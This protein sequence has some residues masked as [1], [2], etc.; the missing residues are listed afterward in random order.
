MQVAL[1]ELWRAW[2][3]D[4]DAVIGHS[5]GEVAAAHVAGALGLDDAVRVIGRRSRL[6]RQLSG[7]GA[8][9]AVDLSWREAQAVIVGYEDRVSIAVSNGR[10]STVLSGDPGAL[11]KILGDLKARNVFCRRIN[12]DVASHSPQVEA[13]EPELQRALSDVA[14]ATARLPIYSTVTGDPVDGKVL[15]A[16]YWIRNVRQ[17]VL[18]GA[19]VE[20]SQRDGFDVFLEVSPHPILLPA[21][22]A[23]TPESDRSV[24]LVPSLRRAEDE[25]VSLRTSAGQLYAA[26]VALDWARLQPT[27]AHCVT[28]PAYPWQRERFWLDPPHETSLGR[29]LR[30]RQRVDLESERWRYEVAWRPR[31]V[32][33]LT[34]TP[35]AW[36]ILADSGGVGAALAAR[37]R[38]SGARVLVVWP[39]TEYQR[40]S[41][42]DL[43]IRPDSQ[44]DFDR[45][46]GESEQGSG[47][48]RLVHLWGLD[49]DVAEADD[50]ARV[51]EAVARGTRSALALLQAAVRARRSEL[52]VWL[53]TRG[54]QALVEATPPAVGQAPVWGLGMVASLDH[55]EVWGGLV[56]LDP[57]SDADDAGALME[58]LRS[59]DGEDRVAFRR[60]ERYVARLGRV[61][62]AATEGAV[63]LQPHATYLVT[64]GLGGLG[65]R[66]ARWAIERGA[67]HL[68]LA[69]RRGA[70]EAAG[71]ALQE[72]ERAG[73]EVVVVSADVGRVE[74]VEA[75][76]ASIRARSLPPL[77]G[78]FHVAGVVDD[79]LLERQDWS[80]VERVMRAKVDGAWNLHRLTTG[81]GLEHFV[82]FSSAVSVVGTPAQAG[83][84]AANAFLDALAH[85]RRRRGL[86]A[87]SVNWGRWGEVG[88]AADEQRAR[89][90][91]ALGFAAMTPDAALEALGR[92]MREDRAQIAVMAFDA[93]AYAAR[94]PGRER[95]LLA[96][97]RAPADP[98]SPAIA[99]AVLVRLRAAAPEERERLLVDH[100]RALVAAIMRFEDP[101]ALDPAQGFFNLGMDSLMA[102]ELKNRLQASLQCSLVS[103]VVFDAPTMLL[104]ARV[105][106]REL[107]GA[108]PAGTV[109]EA[110]G[111]AVADL[112]DL[113][114]LAP[115]ALQRLLADELR[116][117]KAL[118][119]RT[120]G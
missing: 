86:P 4:P 109:A 79:G 56:D 27:D 68:V 64:G 58:A 3:V 108:S 53:V 37:L 24:T 65:L 120:R 28:L 52:R 19:A 48:H 82:L 113:P 33:A 34:T 107:F 73:A 51:R 91:D 93:E 26:G 62:A 99:S 61:P 17:P 112:A 63:R 67:R 116:Q 66:L 11:D 114:D 10:R 41:A 50:V 40:S 88:L 54:A 70:T 83:Y 98:A 14:P 87:L 60:S 25:V 36:T 59:D 115:D 119:D 12:V 94:F 21:I 49:G 100:V 30:R 103:T 16:G 104:L 9:A 101:A 90:L 97:L 15:D 105:L 39:G 71:P 18:F 8:M 7:Q 47:V 55:P 6:L 32:R 89:N 46:L 45:L 75:M 72:L 77:A 102:M 5:M 31:P 78:V 23:S 42:G 95:P 111:D 84:A 118:E 110:G 117:V 44:E 1:A 96:D 92:A 74:D 38:E 22:A 35:S 57:A 81:L 43:T 80:R 29:Q 20:R 106:D 2:G 69:G 85:H 13:L 76:L